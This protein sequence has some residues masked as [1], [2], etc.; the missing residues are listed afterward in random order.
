MSIV[1][2]A[3]GREDVVVAGDSLWSDPSVG[4]GYRLPHSKLVLR[5]EA[6]LVVGA[7]GSARVLQAVR[8]MDLDAPSS[9]QPG[10]WVADI[11]APELLRT[12]RNGLGELSGAEPGRPLG[13]RTMLV[14]AW[15]SQLWLLSAELVAREIEGFVAIGS[16]RHWA[17]GAWSALEGLDLDPL[18]RIHRVLRAAGSYCITIDGPFGYVRT[19][20]LSAVRAFPPDSTC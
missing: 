10:S 2:A 4:E 13:R 14:L 20:D 19:S 16:G 18:D 11:F 15:G 8:S 12:A 17:Y 5:Q 1:T 6:G 3:R 7:V 9:T